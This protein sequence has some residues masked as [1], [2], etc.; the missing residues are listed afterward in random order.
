MCWFTI[1]LETRGPPRFS[2][3]K[4]RISYWVRVERTNTSQPV[5]WGQKLS[6]DPSRPPLLSRAASVLPSL[7]HPSSVTYTHIPPWLPRMS[8]S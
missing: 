5:L 1:T 8:P 7:T 6:T 3:F 4:E 2:H